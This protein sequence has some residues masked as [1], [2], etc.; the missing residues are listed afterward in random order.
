[1]VVQI[2]ET[3]KDTNEADSLPLYWGWFVETE[4]SSSFLSRSNKLL[5]DTLQKVPDFLKDVQNFTKQEF[6]SDILLHYT[7]Q[8][9][10]EVLHC[11]AMYNGV[12]PDYMPGAE[13]YA[14]KQIVKVIHNLTSFY[15][16]WLPKRRKLL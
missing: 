9:A 12:D 5:A 4:Y 15:S 13:E 10:E 1:M 7:R 14:N 3:K 2:V 8:N 16:L 6:I 11:T